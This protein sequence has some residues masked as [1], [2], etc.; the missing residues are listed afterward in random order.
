MINIFH[1]YRYLLNNSL[2]DNFFYGLKTNLEE[3][4]NYDTYRLSNGAGLI[5]TY[6]KRFKQNGVI[7]DKHC[8]EVLLE[9]F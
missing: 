8:N 3:I 9:N 2:T 4:S 7:E 5:K 1:H 6:I